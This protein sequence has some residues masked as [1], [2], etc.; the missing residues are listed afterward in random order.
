M[1]ESFDIKSIPN[2][3]KIKSAVNSIL[4]NCDF[5]TMTLKSLRFELEKKYSCSFDGKKDVIREELEKYLEENVDVVEYSEKINTEKLQLKNKE[6]IKND[7]N[8]SGVE[9]QKKGILIIQLT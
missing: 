4:Q 5:T 1:S 6:G 3:K 8:Q 7:P 9:I 2:D